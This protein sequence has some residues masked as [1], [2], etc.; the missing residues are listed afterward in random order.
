[1]GRRVMVEYDSEK[2]QIQKYDKAKWEEYEKIELAWFAQ[3]A[4]DSYTLICKELNFMT[5]CSSEELIEK[6]KELR[7]KAAKARPILD[8]WQRLK[9]HME[10]NPTIKEEWEGLLMAIRLT[11]ED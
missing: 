11:E 3:N 10:T 8:D 7:T 4:R 6:L 9:E 2:Y 1:M 5:L